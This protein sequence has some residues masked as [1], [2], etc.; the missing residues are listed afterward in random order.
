[1]SGAATSQTLTFGQL[2]QLWT[3]AGG[4]PS[5]APLMAAIALAES[6]GNPQAVNPNDTNGRGGTQTSWGLWQISNGTHQQPVSGILNP[7]T[8]AQQAVAKLH[9]QGLTAWGTYDSGAYE[10]YLPGGSSASSAASAATG[11]TGSGVPALASSS[12]L[13][14]AS[15]NQLLTAGM[16]NYAEQNPAEFGFPP[17]TLDSA[18]QSKYLKGWRGYGLANPQS[19][20]LGFSFLFVNVT[21]IEQGTVRKIAG[22]AIAVGG[23]FLTLVGLLMTTKAIGQS[24]SRAARVIQQLP[25]VGGAADRLGSIGQTGAVPAGVSSTPEEAGGFGADAGELALAG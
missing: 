14:S 23:A 7:L 15:F 19:K 2:E 1:M 24:D 22:G 25:L 10:Q 5:M 17:T 8:N 18:T 21:F 4:S 6:S 11:S 16:E 9:S 12:Q 20:A 13:S 3:Q